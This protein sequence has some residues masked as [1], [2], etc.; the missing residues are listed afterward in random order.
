MLATPCPSLWQILLRKIKTPDT[1]RT[2]FSAVTMLIA[3]NIQRHLVSEVTVSGSSL[4]IQNSLNYPHFSNC[5]K[6]ANS[7][8]VGWAT[9][10][11]N[12]IKQ[13]HDCSICSTYPVVIF[14]VGVHKE[15]LAT[16]FLPQFI[17]YFMQAHF[18]MLWFQWLQAL[19]KVKGK[20]V[21]NIL[22]MI[23]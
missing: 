8:E 18:S 6:Q 15:T 2:P 22:I 3:N 14:K 21:I 20:T 1:P 13:Q 5:P 7:S 10:K 16:A 17:E 11:T 9:K 12:Y 19:Y 23:I 4:Y